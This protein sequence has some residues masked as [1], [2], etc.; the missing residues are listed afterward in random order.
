MAKK[1][2]KVGE[3]TKNVQERTESVQGGTDKATSQTFGWTVVDIICL[4]AIMTG[5]YPL[6]FGFSTGSCVRSP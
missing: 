6:R 2:R 5:K 1:D 3:G 4:K